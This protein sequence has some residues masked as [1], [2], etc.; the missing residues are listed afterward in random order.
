MIDLSSFGITYFPS[1]QHSVSL[2]PSLPSHF[3]RNPG[4]QD[5]SLTQVLY[6]AHSVNPAQD[7]VGGAN[8]YTSPI[9][10]S[11]A[12]NI[13]LQYNVFFPAGFGWVRGG[14]LP[15]LYGDRMGYSDG[16]DAENC[17]STRLMWRAGG[18][19]GIALF[20]AWVN[21]QHGLWV[22]NWSWLLR[23]DEWLL[24]TVTQTLVL[25]AEEKAHG[26]FTLW[27][28]DKTGCILPRPRPVF[29]SKAYQDDFWKPL[30]L[31]EAIP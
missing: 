28:N 22:F 2:V 14:N 19:A 21:M 25:N 9:D 16:I 1:G 7:P 24:D 18:I 15:G 12:T 3:A 11:S 4:E 8:F 29:S 5:Q 23:L 17:F 26:W 31:Q 20:I 27:V 30:V 6:P 10:L 13:T